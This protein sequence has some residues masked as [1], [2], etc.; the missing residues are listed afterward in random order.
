MAAIMLIH[1]YPEALPLALDA[2]G[3]RSAV[4]GGGRDDR[5]VPGG[6]LR[7]EIRVALRSRLGPHAQA[8]SL[9]LGP[10]RS[11]SAARPADDIE[12]PVCCLQTRHPCVRAPGPPVL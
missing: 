10:R 11:P 6:N 12:S 4:F 7:G 2:K 9:H 3:P 1:R 5:D 8:A